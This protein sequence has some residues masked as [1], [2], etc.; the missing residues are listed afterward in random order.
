MTGEETGTPV[1]PA[2]RARTTV[3]RSAWFVGRKDVGHMLRRRE[4][5]LWTFVMPPVFFFFIG[6]ITG[7]F[8]GGDMDHEPI[9]LAAPADAGFLAD[10]LTRRLEGQ[11]FSVRPASAAASTPR[12]CPGCGCPRGSPTRSWRGG[13]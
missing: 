2:D 10:H 1:A 11:G 9:V 4:T 8:A 3:L 6:T 7:G 13:P 5:L 12:A